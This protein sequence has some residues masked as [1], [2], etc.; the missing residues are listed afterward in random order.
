MMRKI[1]GD[2]LKID[3]HPCQPS[4]GTQGDKNKMLTATPFLKASDQYM[5]AS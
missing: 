5:L 2:A 1:V 3:F 4:A